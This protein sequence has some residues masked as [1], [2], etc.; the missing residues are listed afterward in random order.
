MR[1]KVCAALVVLSCYMSLA[2]VAEAQQ[3]T[4]TEF[5]FE[6]STLFGNR[7]QTKTD[8][9]IGGRFTYN[10]AANLALEADANHYVTRG[11]VFSV[12]ADGRATSA[13]FGPK[14]GIR[15]NRFGIF[16]KARPGFVSF[17]D[18]LT[19]ASVQ[20]D[21]STA[22][23]THAAFD[24]G[25][26]FELYPS[27]RMIVRIDVGEVL[28]RYG[29]ATLLSSGVFAVR[30][31]GTIDTPLHLSVGASY[32]LGALHKEE[33]VSTPP[34]RVQFGIQY[35]LQTLERAGLIVRDESAIGGWSTYE[36][37]RHFAVD[38]AV[39]FFPR[40]MKFI[41]PNQ[42][43]RMFQ[44]LA[45]LRWGIRRDNYGVFLK[46]RPGVQMYSLTEATDNRLELTANPQ[47]PAFTDLALDT[48]G[49]FEIYTSKHTLLRFD[50]GDTTI[51]FRQRKLLDFQGNPF[52]QSGA[53]KSSLQLTG[54][55]GWRL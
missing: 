24:L 34:R 51:H 7:I 47:F 4:R 21:L 1:E 17:S 23:K 38:S 53:T 33:Q 36:L 15:K 43:G 29:D 3:F 8:S 32:R 30:T 25:G 49:V 12:Q 52:T 28:V 42:G 11:T 37:G 18:V 55:F 27:R 13:F 54:G 35:S 22:R 19:S 45:G 44:A 48:G 40:R 41:A 31:I 10:L 39:N 2:S 6:S 16:F 50:A 14:A 5:G 20:G 26:V 9:G 46:V